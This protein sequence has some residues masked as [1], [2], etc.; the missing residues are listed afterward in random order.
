MLLT[1]VPKIGDPLVTF[2]IQYHGVDTLQ[3]VNAVGLFCPCTGAVLLL[4]IVP[5]LAMCQVSLGLT[6]RKKHEEIR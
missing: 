2:S 6:E 4:P 3:K 1:L 5:S